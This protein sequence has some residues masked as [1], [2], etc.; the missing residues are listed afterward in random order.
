MHTLR[1]AAQLIRE[2]ADRINSLPGVEAAGA[3]CCVPL[4]GGFGLP[5]VIL[6]RPLNG[7]TFHGGGGFV[8]VS[9]TYFSVFRIPVVRGRAFT[10]RDDGGA[11]GVAIINQAMARRFWP[12]GNPL[13]DRLT[14]GTA[15]GPQLEL[16]DRQIVGV[17][18]DVRSA[19]LN[20]EPQP[21]MY[22]PWAQVPDAHSANLLEIASLSWIVRT[23]V[24]P[25]SLHSN[26]R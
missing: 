17:V 16:R 14:I 1:E 20:R 3:T 10:D 22:V 5:F 15:L 2:G 9:P 19:G 24:E 21:A 25:H 7:S 6:G 4:Q 11:P 13:V 8:P 23:R 18:G 26:S 12:N